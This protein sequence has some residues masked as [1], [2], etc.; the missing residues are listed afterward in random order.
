MNGISYDERRDLVIPG[1]YN[2]TLLFCVDHFVNAAKK[3]IQDHDYFAV[4]L[5]GGST[6]KAIYERLALPQNKDKIQWDK[7]LIFWSDERAVPPESSESNYG[8]AMKAGLETLPLNWETVFR[9]K[10]EAE[11]IEEAAKEYEN[12]IIE[13]V[14]NQMF[15]LIMLGVG[16]D[17]HTAS[18]FPET[19]GLHAEGRL[20]IANYLPHVE[21]WRLSMTFDCINRAKQACIY[22]MGSSKASIVKTVLTSGYNPDHLPSQRVGTAANKALWVLDTAAASALSVT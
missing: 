13:N 14:P 6:P 21:K 20:V 15:D 1:D 7:C 17:G 11:D 12:L 8:M 18:L 19:H 2:E 5:S 22:A 10:G 4:A 16:E 3:A 9:M